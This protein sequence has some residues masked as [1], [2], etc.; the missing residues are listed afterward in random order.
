VSRPLP[1]TGAAATAIQPP[2]TVFARLR[3]WVFVFD[4]ILLAVLC[5][6]ALLSLVTMYSAAYEFPGR[7]EVHARN[8][9][10]AAAVMWV[11]A[12]LPR[13]WLLRVALPLFIFG[14][15]LL[16]AVALVGDVAKGAEALSGLSIPMFSA[17]GL[18]VKRAN[19]EVIFFFVVYVFRGCE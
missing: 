19:G 9:L 10:L 14:V 17:K 1:Q 13:E 5:A 11:G 12:V 15:A 8:M 18:V 2:Q 16:V 3:P 7:L 4:P 6:I